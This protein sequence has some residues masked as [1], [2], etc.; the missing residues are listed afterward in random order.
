M[1]FYSIHSSAFTF[2]ALAGTR[3]E[4]P[5]GPVAGRTGYPLGRTSYELRS[6][7]QLQSVQGLSGTTL[8]WSTGDGSGQA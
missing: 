3:F 2:T 6:S 8:G 5:N 1:Q 4:A 7:D